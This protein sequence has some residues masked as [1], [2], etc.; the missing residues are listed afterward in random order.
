MFGRAG[1]G[2]R[3]DLYNRADHDEL[4]IR[5]GFS[6]CVEQ[7]QIHALIDDSAIPDAGMRDRSLILRLKLREGGLVQNEPRRRCWET[8]AYSR[9]D[10][11]SIRRACGRP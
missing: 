11:F 9:A 10:V 2:S 1:R 8:R 7:R 6:N 5:S 3:I 4:P